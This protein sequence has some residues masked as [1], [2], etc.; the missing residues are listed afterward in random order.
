MQ[1]LTTQQVADMLGV[2]PSTLRA[3]RCAKT[4]PPFIRITAQSVKY[5]AEDID[6]FLAE[7]RITPYV[8]ASEVNKHAVAIPAAGHKRMD[9]R[10]CK[11]I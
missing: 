2:K 1:L 9:L 8:R 6:R 11:G 3:W 4:G 10:S 5:A 7:R